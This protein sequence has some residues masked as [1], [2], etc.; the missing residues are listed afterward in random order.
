MPRL[1]DC[2]SSIDFQGS[3]LLRARRTIS[4]CA[5]IPLMEVPFSK[6][7]LATSAWVLVGTLTRI[8]PLN[9]R[10]IVSPPFDYT[11]IPWYTKGGGGGRRGR[12]I[13]LFFL[14]W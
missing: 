11:T 12:R 7:S 10:A 6:A 4:A 1:A 2:A 14:Q 3:M 9:V 5:K 8:C 13:L